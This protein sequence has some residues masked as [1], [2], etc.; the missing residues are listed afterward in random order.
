MHDE[1]G[2]AEQKKTTNTDRY[3]IETINPAESTKAETC[4]TGQMLLNSTEK[5]VED[6]LN[7]E[8]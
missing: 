2:N 1:Y 4:E 3:S 7:D 6:R 5:S 8:P